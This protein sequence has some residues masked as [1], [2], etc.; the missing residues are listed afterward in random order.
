MDS[1]CIFQDSLLESVLTGTLD[2][3]NFSTVEYI[4]GRN[5]LYKEI[6]DIYN[7]QSGGKDIIEEAM[8]NLIKDGTTKF[9]DN[10]KNAVSLNDNFTKYN[11]FLTKMSSIV[12]LD[13]NKFNYYYY[14]YLNLDGSESYGT[15]D[16]MPLVGQEEAIYDQVAMISGNSSELYKKIYD[17]VNFDFVEGVEN[18]GTLSEYYANRTAFANVIKLD[19]AAGTGK[20]KVVALTTIKIAEQMSESGKTIATAATSAMAKDLYKAFSDADVNLIDEQLGVDDMIVRL[21]ENDISFLKGVNKMFIDEASLMQALN[22]G[23]KGSD[24]FDSSS[25]LFNY[26]HSTLNKRNPGIK[27]IMLGDS[28]QL[29]Y[30]NSEGQEEGLGLRSASKSGS[31]LW[32][33]ALEVTGVMS[34]EPLTDSFRTSSYLLSK[35]HESLRNPKTSEGWLFNNIPLKGKYAK[36]KSGNKR[37]LGYR[38]TEGSNKTDKKYDSNK[39]INDFVKAL[40]ETVDGEFS[41]IDSIEQQ[42]SDFEQ[43]GKIFEVI[44]AADLGMKQSVFLAELEKTDIGKRFVDLI[45]GKSKHKIKFDYYGDVNANNK[46]SIVEAQGQ[47]A[48]YVFFNLTNRSIKS[49]KASTAKDG[50]GLAIASKTYKHGVSVAYMLTTRARLYAHSINNHMTMDIETKF[51]P[52]VYDVL[53]QTDILDKAQKAKSFYVAVYKDTNEQMVD[54]NDEHSIIN[55]GKEVLISGSKKE[56]SINDDT[57]II[58]TGLDEFKTLAESDTDKAYEQLSQV[59]NMYSESDKE[60]NKKLEGLYNELRNEIDLE[61][62]RV[63]RKEINNIVNV[64]NIREFLM[65]N[66]VLVTEDMYS[67]EL[68]SENFKEEKKEL[69]DTR[70]KRLI[71]SIE[72]AKASG[73]KEDVEMLYQKMANI[74]ATIV[75]ELMEKR[76]YAYGYTGYDQDRDGDSRKYEDN[77]VM[78]L[79]GYKANEISTSYNFK[80]D[81]LS[82]NKKG[83]NYK[84]KIHVKR[85]GSKYRVYVVAQQQLEAGKSGK[86]ILLLSTYSDKWNG[87]ASKEFFERIKSKLD[88]GDGV[89]TIDNIKFSDIVSSITPGKIKRTKDKITLKEFFTNVD[90]GKVKNEHLNVSNIIYTYVGKNPNLRG[91][92]FLIYTQSENINVNTNTFSAWIDEAISSGE[93]TEFKGLYID[94]KNNRHKVGMLML[95][96]KPYSFSDIYTKLSLKDNDFDSKTK[97]SVYTLLRSYNTMPAVTALFASLYVAINEND[98]QVNKT[99]LFKKLQSLTES[100]NSV[101]KLFGNDFYRKDNLNKF[102][103]AINEFGE[104]NIGKLKVFLDTIFA[105][106]F[107]GKFGSY[108]GKVVEYGEDKEKRYAEKKEG[109]LFTLLDPIS[110]D[111]NDETVKF[112]GQYSVKLN[113][114]MASIHNSEDNPEALL[115]MLDKASSLTVYLSSGLRTRFTSDTSLSGVEKTKVIYIKDADNKDGVLNSEVEELLINVE[116]I[117]DPNVILNIEGLSKAFDKA[118]ITDETKTPVSIGL[119]GSEEALT[120]DSKEKVE[121]VPIKI[122]TKLDSNPDI[123][124]SETKFEKQDKN[125]IFGSDKMVNVKSSNPEAYNAL[126]VIY[127]KLFSSPLNDIDTNDIIEFEKELFSITEGR[128]LNAN[129]VKKM[130]SY[131]DSVKSGDVKKANNNILSIKVCK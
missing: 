89:Y 95:D 39:V 110:L 72:K 97:D 64:L 44:Y 108:T 102:K 63:L 59:A 94:G 24:K 1:K 11:S 58:T 126:S 129:K 62:I 67:L 73:N 68:N 10:N 124:V 12:S 50:E 107:E 25:A 77:D 88:V 90:N 79:L 101:H 116:E 61:K 51:D 30:F 111:V 40:S 46:A 41:I 106:K 128:E 42:A 21:E 22:N 9:D 118:N 17:T 122:E 65:D 56:V 36:S 100:D 127:D 45:G 13:I 98:E 109:A 16:F 18:I 91:K 131:I 70:G 69:L 6:Y 8:V 123:K 112:K 60:L 83:Y 71:D 81:A 57:K 20:T 87:D 35:V 49:M 121:N 85:E 23:F 86:N 54:I 55:W 26:L 33:N 15:K 119:K 99:E 115:K 82:L 80:R 37:I 84:Y 48:D 19:A 76:G 38:N 43:E 66:N 34:S 105:A 117:G 4:E 74:E 92:Q 2:T 27:I 125:I 47:E 78:K 31:P 113:G 96:N 120:F 93:K 75:A 7:N 103:A 3:S 114:I 14:N 28:S 104:D 53:S 32:T 52:E 29:S 5:K 130:T